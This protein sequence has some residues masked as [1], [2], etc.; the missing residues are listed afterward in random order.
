MGSDM[1]QMLDRQMQGKL[2]SWAIRWCYHQYKYDLFSA[3]P[4]VSKISNIGFNSLDATNTTEKF[5]R[6]KTKLD[7]SNKT[8]FQ[9]SNDI[10]LED[11]I[12]NQFIK[13]FTILSRL[14]YKIIHLVFKN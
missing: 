5:N 12:I 7:Q 10:C 2:D 9:F 3:H 4:M 13:P 6:Y 11:K 8:S 14:K 1:S